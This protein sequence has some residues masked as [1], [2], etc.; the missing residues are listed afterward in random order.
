MR[1]TVQDSA[2]I[3]IHIPKSAGTTLNRIIE[4]EYPAFQIFSLIG[5]Y[6]WSYDRLNGWSQ[7]RLARTRVFKGHMPFGLHMLLPQSATYI[8]MLRNPVDRA[9]SSYYYRLSSRL[10]PQHRATKQLTLEQHIR[11]SPL[12]NI[13]T[14]LLAGGAGAADFLVDDCNAET[15]ATAKDNLARHFSLIGLTER[16]DE[17]L[18]LAKLLF[19]WKITRYARFRVTQNRPKMETI[20]PRVRDLIKDHC[21][22]DIGLYQYATTLF[23]QALADRA[24]D[25]QFQLDAIRQA[26]ISTL[27][28][29]LYYQTA[30]LARQALCLINSQL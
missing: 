7:S 3:F 27:R 17:S 13:Q 6:R 20:S 18:A 24:S 22:F 23:E 5:R 30:S 19:G 9:I 12:N 2:V 26:N 14:R 29:S 10:H 11:T 25:V 28:D 1:Q 15:L 21:Q 4:W 16:F 8:T